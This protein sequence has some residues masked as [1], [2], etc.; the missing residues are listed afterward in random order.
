MTTVLINVLTNVLNVLTDGRQTNCAACQL[1]CMSTYSVACGDGVTLV[2]D[3]FVFFICAAPRQV[4]LEKQL[5]GGSAPQSWRLSLSAGWPSWPDPAKSRSVQVGSWG[6][7][8]LV[9]GGALGAPEDP[10]APWRFLGALGPWGS[11]SLGCPELPGVLCEAAV[12]TEPYSAFTQP[13]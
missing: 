8:P 9:P 1:C 10:G 11:G 2:F 4:F 3:V 13:R 6:L 7:G 12:V 5:L